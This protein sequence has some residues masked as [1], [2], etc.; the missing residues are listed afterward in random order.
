[1]VDW[2]YISY[3]SISKG[4]F[5]TIVNQDGRIQPHCLV[6]YICLANRVYTHTMKGKFELP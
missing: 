3:F 1:M 4:Q 2:Y 6:Y 5:S